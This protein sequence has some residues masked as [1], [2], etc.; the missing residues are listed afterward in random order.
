MGTYRVLR[1]DFCLIW[2]FR[3]FGFS[4]VMFVVVSGL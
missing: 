4:L 2:G 1:V 3:V